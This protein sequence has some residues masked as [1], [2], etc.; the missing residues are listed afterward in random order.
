MD[1]RNPS[2]W[3][4]KSVNVLGALTRVDLQAGTARIRHYGKELTV[5]LQLLLPFH[6]RLRSK[7]MFIGELVLEENNEEEEEVS[8]HHPPIPCFR[9]SSHSLSLGSP[10]CVLFVFFF[11]FILDRSRLLRETAL[12]AL[13]EMITAHQE[14]RT[15]GG[16]GGEGEEVRDWSSSRETSAA[17]TTS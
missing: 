1:I 16:G 3:H 10:P 11:F 7:Y 12:A 14:Q 4:Q 15:K 9:V 2:E 13:M 17:W 8:L 5:R 6:Y